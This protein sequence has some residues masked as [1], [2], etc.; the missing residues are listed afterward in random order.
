MQ[1]KRHAVSRNNCPASGQECSICHKKGHY[2]RKCKSKKDRAKKEV[3]QFMVAKGSG[4]SSSD[5]ENAFSIKQPSESFRPPVK[6]SINGIKG[7]MDADSCSSANI[8]DESLFKA[9]AD[10][11]GIQLCLTRRSLYAYAQ[12]NPIKLA[13]S[14]Q[15]NVRSLETGEETETEF[16]GITNSRPL[17]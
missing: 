16:L 3:K 11:T 9:V 14:I 8:M 17:L 2:A 6:V 4:Y 10:R 15:V 5:S 1:V 12:Q 13:G 7:R